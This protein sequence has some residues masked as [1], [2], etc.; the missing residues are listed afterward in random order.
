MGKKKSVPH[1]SYGSRR[2]GGTKYQRMLEEAAKP[3]NKR[4]DEIDDIFDVD[5]DYDSD[6]DDLEEESYMD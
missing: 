6:D 4:E 1:G 5:D 3:P 2:M